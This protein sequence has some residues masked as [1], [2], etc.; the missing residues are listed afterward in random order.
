[1]HSQYGCRYA[2]LLKK[3]WA[4][5]KVSDVCLRAAK[6]S[7]LV[8][9]A[10]FPENNSSMTSRLSLNSGIFWTGYFSEGEKR[11][12]EI[13]LLSQD[14]LLSH[15]R[16]NLRESKVLLDKFFRDQK[17]DMTSTVTWSKCF[18]CFSLFLNYLSCHKLASFCKFSQPY[19]FFVF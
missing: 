12:Q 18:D 1:M 19:I 14:N 4:S 2:A 16:E 9:S 11:R 5:W 8:L 6:Q 13:R 17:R 10:I 7:T 3:L 15:G